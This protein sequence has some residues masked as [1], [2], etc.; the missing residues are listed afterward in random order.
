MSEHEDG[1]ELTGSAAT[2]A[3]SKAF[4]RA[5]AIN[6]AQRELEQSALACRNHN[7]GPVDQEETVDGECYVLVRLGDFD[8]LQAALEQLAKAKAM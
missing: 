4:P 5:V 6:K 3:I 7:G 2:D 8:A 1:Q